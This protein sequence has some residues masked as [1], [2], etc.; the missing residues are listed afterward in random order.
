MK[1]KFFTPQAVEKNVKATVHKTG[2]LGFTKQAATKLNLSTGLFLKIAA[3]EEDENDTNL[4]AILSKTA[5][6]EGFK[7]SKAGGYFFSNIK[8]VLDSIELDYK[9]RTYIYDIT[10]KEIEGVSMYVLNRRSIDK[11]EKASN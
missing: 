5:D 2:K 3:N 11:K 8:E 4:Y 9:K 7:I 10:E 1:L 6:N